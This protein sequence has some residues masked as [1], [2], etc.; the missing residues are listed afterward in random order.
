MATY[1]QGVTDY[2]PQ[3]QPW[4]PNYNFYQPIFQQKQ[5]KYDQGWNKA[6]D[7]YNSVLNAPMLRED[8][9]LKRDDFFKNAQQQIKQLSGVDLSLAQNQDAAAQVFAPFYEDQSIVKDMGF[10]KK[11]QDEMQRAEYL[12]NCTDPAKCGD[13]YWSGGVRAM[14]Y[15]AEDFVNASADEA[16]KMR[17]PQYTEYYNLMKNAQAAVKDSGLSMKIDSKQGGYIVT[18]KNGSQLTMPLMN[19]MMSRFGD[20]PKLQ[21]FYSTKAM[22]LTRENP[23]VANAM[24]LKSMQNAGVP[25]EQLKQQAENET[26]TKTYTDSKQVIGDTA[27]KEENRFM[28]MVRR[29]DILEAN[30]KKNGV[31]PGSPEANSFMA[32]V[33]D[34]N[35]QEGVVNRFKNMNEAANNTDEGL[36]KQGLAANKHQ[37]TNV[38]AN[39]MKIKDMYSTANS[40]AYRDYERTMKADP[41]AVANNSFSNQVKLAS[42]KNQYSLTSKAYDYI[43]SKGLADVKNAQKVQSV[44]TGIPFYSRPSNDYRSRLG[45]FENTGR[46]TS[47]INTA[48]TQADQLSSMILSGMSNP[49]SNVSAN[50]ELIDKLIQEGRLEEALTVS[51]GHTRYNNEERYEALDEALSPG[52]LTYNPDEAGDGVNVMKSTLERFKLNKALL[53][54]LNF[55]GGLPMYKFSMDHTPETIQ[56]MR[57][58]F[59][60]ARAYTADRINSFK[61]KSESYKSEIN[62]D[63]LNAQFNIA[64]DETHPDSDKVQIEMLDLTSHIDANFKNWGKRLES[65]FHGNI[66][67]DYAAYK[68]AADSGWGDIPNLTS[69]EFKTLRWGMPS[70]GSNIWAANSKQFRKIKNIG[71]DKLIALSGGNDGLYKFNEEAGGIWAPNDIS[72]D[73]ASR[74]TIKDESKRPADEV[75]SHNEYAIYQKLRHD[76]AGNRNND[77]SYVNP[78]LS[79]EV[80]DKLNNYETFTGNTNFERK[81]GAGSEINSLKMLNATHAPLKVQIAN[82]DRGAQKAIDNHN[83][84]LSNAANQLVPNTNSVDGRIW[85]S[86]M[87]KLIIPGG[88]GEL[89]RIATMSELNGIL[90]ESIPELMSDQNNMMFHNKWGYNLNE[91]RNKNMN[92]GKTSTKSM[93]NLLSQSNYASKVGASKGALTTVYEHPDWNS[94]GPAYTEAIAGWKF[95]QDQKKPFEERQYTNLGQALAET[96]TENPL[97]KRSNTY[98][99]TYKSSGTVMTNEDKDEAY[100]TQAQKFLQFLGKYEDAVSTKYKNG[101]GEFNVSPNYGWYDRYKSQSDPR[102]SSMASMKFDLGKAKLDK[103]WINVFEDHN[104][105]IGTA[106]EELLNNFT[107][108]VSSFGGMFPGKDGKPRGQGTAVSVPALMSGITPNRQDQSYFDSKY[109]I[110]EGLQKGK[111]KEGSEIGAEVLNKLQ[112]SLNDPEGFSKGKAPMWDLTTKP[113]SGAYNRT[114]Y[115]LTLV[116]DTWL[117]AQGYNKKLGGDKGIDPNTAAPTTYEWSVDDP[118]DAISLGAHPTAFDATVGNLGVGETYTNTAIGKDY[119]NIHYSK[120]DEGS[121]K[122]GYTID[123]FNV[124][125]GEEEEITFYAPTQAYYGTDWTDQQITLV[126]EMM[127]AKS[128]SNDMKKQYTAIRG[129]KDTDALFRQMAEQLGISPEELLQSFK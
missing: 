1:I 93:F 69:E 4:K 114:T 110:K 55:V 54:D 73:I 128:I 99:N 116:D 112:A 48:E 119:G 107:D 40:L 53:K 63:I 51:K 57:N 33:R 91:F 45:T 20:D 121:V 47:S 30:V 113:T 81:W 58:G 21:E 89:S 37:M 46:S 104:N 27:T 49:M 108:G 75:M 96:Q 76:E 127:Q 23:E 41:F 29:K 74:L 77:G 66:S 44:G 15:Q 24:Y 124:Q 34:A 122:P 123:L 92:D 9:K 80:I 22:L 115:K 79:P 7:M 38:I 64:G 3:V 14:N 31:V 36:Q 95:D 43:Y 106:Y 126:N 50:P 72:P 68:R 86:I 39:A 84:A 78:E 117:G 11:Y 82:E 60:S 111:F 17:A 10:T 56:R 6:N 32:S 35:V 98:S 8:N 70:N 67:T 118:T 129:I 125:T 88:D 83:I 109:I 100:N 28:A 61:E 62:K 94:V 103:S 120:T 65:K 18:T 42:I 90:A 59:N 71:I 105:T 87:D 25:E 12:R 5:A 16:L 97:D 85:N 102:G 52:N 13:K 101:G 19:F 26:F 2:V